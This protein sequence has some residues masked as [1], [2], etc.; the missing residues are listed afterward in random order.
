MD[1]WT[2]AHKPKTTKENVLQVLELSTSVLTYWLEKL[3]RHREIYGLDIFSVRN[4][5]MQQNWFRARLAC[6][7]SL[8]LFSSTIS[9]FSLCLFLTIDIGK[10]IYTEYSSL[11]C[12]SGPLCYTQWFLINSQARVVMR[13]LAMKELARPRGRKSQKRKGELQRV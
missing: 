2:E 6:L 12:F 3:A 4:Q 1:T 7:H 8:S 13:R 5:Y 9:F 10:C 11:F